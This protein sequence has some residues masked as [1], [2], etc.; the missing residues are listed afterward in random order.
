[1]NLVID[2]VKARLQSL[3]YKASGNDDMAL[4]FALTKV[5]NEFKNFC[6]IKTIPAQVEAG[7][8]DRVCGDFLFAKAQ[9]GEL[10]DVFQIDQAIKSIKMGDTDITYAE[11]SKADKINMLIAHLQGKAGDWV[12]F[13]RLKW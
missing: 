6:H 4:S 1:M 10:D 5:E 12:C 13:R 9:S 3:G 8:I 11:G 7:L 2:Q